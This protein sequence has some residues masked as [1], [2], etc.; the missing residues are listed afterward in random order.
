MLMLLQ[1]EASRAK[2]TRRRV[3]VVVGVGAALQQ[4]STCM[5]LANAVHARLAWK[6]T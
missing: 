2:E 6:V 1:L 4:V 5:Q 3:V